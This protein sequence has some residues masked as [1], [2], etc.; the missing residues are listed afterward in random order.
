MRFQSK[1][2]PAALLDA[3]R[4]TA[5]LMLLLVFVT[6]FVAL[7]VF[8]SAIAWAIHTTAELKTWKEKH[9]RFI[10]RENDAAWRANREMI[11]Y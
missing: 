7:A 9:S 5:M 2:Q 3:R 10:A 1:V 8:G 6:S 4:K 11:V